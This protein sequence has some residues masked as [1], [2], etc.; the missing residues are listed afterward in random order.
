MSNVYKRQVLLHLCSF[1]INIG[2]SPE[3][4][5]LHLNPRFDAHGDVRAVVCNSYQGGR[6]C[7]EYRPDGF[8]F[9]HGEEFKVGLKNEFLINNVLD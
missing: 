7:Q 8:S 3:E 4:L 1:A 2:S 9:N 6:W 5:A